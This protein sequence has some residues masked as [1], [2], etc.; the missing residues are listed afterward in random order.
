MPYFNHTLD[1]VLSTLSS[2]TLTVS[3][4]AQAQKNLR[5]CAKNADDK[6]GLAYDF[7]KA[8]Q[9]KERTTEYNKNIFVKLL[10]RFNELATEMIHKVDLVDLA[11]PSANEKEKDVDF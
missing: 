8:C 11:K 9:K 5:E 6:F 2:K 3:T 10:N 1:D 7:Y 4:I